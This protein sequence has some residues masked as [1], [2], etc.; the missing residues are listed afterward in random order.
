[1]GKTKKGKKFAVHKQNICLADDIK[2]SQFEQGS[3]ERKKTGR[4]K[5]TEED[6]V[7]ILIYRKLLLIR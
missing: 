5:E 6:E 2:N 4:K 1:M 3:K 7:R